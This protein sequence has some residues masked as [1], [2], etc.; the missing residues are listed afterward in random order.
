MPGENTWRGQDRIIAPKALVSRCARNEGVNQTARTV[1]L[2]EGRALVVYANSFSHK[3]ARYNVRS[4]LQSSN[5][6]LHKKN[7]I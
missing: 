2:G 5:V 7:G 3:R 1:V 6:Y 4:K